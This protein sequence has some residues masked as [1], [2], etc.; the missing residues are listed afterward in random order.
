MNMGLLGRAGRRGLPLGFGSLV[1][2]VLA[3]STAWACVSHGTG[4]VAD[5]H[6]IIVPRDTPD[7]G[8]SYCMIHPLNSSSCTLGNRDGLGGASARQ[9]EVVESRVSLGIDEKPYKAA[10]GI[11]L[12]KNTTCGTSAT[13]IYH[14]GPWAP[15]VDGS[16]IAE[17]RVP[18]A[19]PLGS[20][21]ACATK[22]SPTNTAY[23][24]V[25]IPT[26]VVEFTV[27]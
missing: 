10:Y 25:N 27:V 1:C 26:T 12:A 6:H 20:Y 16:F 22:A 3:A 8:Q 7:V 24:A 14:F 19:A 2:I 11:R 5:S 23:T 9:N 17:W 4:T 15:L 18:A 21:R 13:H